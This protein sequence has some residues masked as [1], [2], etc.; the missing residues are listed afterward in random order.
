MKAI[1]LAVV[2]LLVVGA[3]AAA[4]FA[5]R[6]LRSG[7]PAAVAEPPLD[8]TPILAGQ[9]VEGS[10]FDGVVNGIRIFPSSPDKSDFRVPACDASPA[11]EV[12]ASTAYGTELDFKFPSNWEVLFD[13][14]TACGDTLVVFHRELDSP[15]GAVQVSRVRADHSIGLNA[16]AGQVSAVTINGKPA[17]FIAAKDI[18]GGYFSGVTMVIVRESFGMTLVKLVNP[19]DTP[20]ALELADQVE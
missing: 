6:A 17:A 19:D 3:G 7:E 2:L 15:I 5:A 13:L 18:G 9:D 1:R 16:P 14:A 8:E 11:V 12:D 10:L 4:F 20:R